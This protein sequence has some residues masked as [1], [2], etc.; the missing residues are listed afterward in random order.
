VI[1][2]FQS[3]FLVQLR[4]LEQL[5]ELQIIPVQFFILS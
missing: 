1:D 4:F 5:A 2:I 3:R